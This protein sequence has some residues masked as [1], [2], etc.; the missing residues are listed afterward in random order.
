MPVETDQ[1]PQGT[2]QNSKPRAPE[3]AEEKANGKLDD[4]FGLCCFGRKGEVRQFS[5]TKFQD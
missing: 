3:V 1:E 2:R 4:T 5:M